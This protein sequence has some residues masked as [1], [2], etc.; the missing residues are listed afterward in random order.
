MKG[1]SLRAKIIAMATLAVFVT[2]LALTGF[3]AFRL[4]DMTRDNVTQRVDGVSN[5]VGKGVERWLSAKYQLLNT[6]A[7]RPADQ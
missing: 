2:S 3:S 1:L 6:L 4:S 5:A 7:E